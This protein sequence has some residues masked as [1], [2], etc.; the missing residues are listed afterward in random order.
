MEIKV[1]ATAY[2]NTAGRLPLF[3]LSVRL[4]SQK[5]KSEKNIAL[6]WALRHTQSANVKTDTFCPK[7]TPAILLSVRERVCLIV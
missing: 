4:Q 6:G 7:R 2:A 3:C 5:P 1:A